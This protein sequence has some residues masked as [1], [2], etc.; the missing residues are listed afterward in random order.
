METALIF[1]TLASTHRTASHRCLL[2]TSFSFG[3]VLTPFS[4]N[5]LR[6]ILRHADRRHPH[7][8]LLP[9]SRRR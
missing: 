2:S 1:F 3:M 9:H 5:R 7:S 4:L 6:C 8:L